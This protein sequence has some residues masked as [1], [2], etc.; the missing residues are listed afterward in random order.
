MVMVICLV[1]RVIVGGW[2]TDSYPVGGGA[3]VVRA[4]AVGAPCHM[5]C[6]V[7]VSCQTPVR[8]SIAVDRSVGSR[9]AKGMSGLHS[10]RTRGDRH[11]S[12]VEAKN[13]ALLSNRDRY[14]WELTG[15]T[16]GSQAS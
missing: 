6:R 4:G 7:G 14:L 13:P 15:W 1:S 3:S 8:G 10:R 5:A 11:S 16:Q 9:A 12:R 2:R